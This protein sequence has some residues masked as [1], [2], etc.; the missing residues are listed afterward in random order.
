MCAG[1]SARSHVPMGGLLTNVCWHVPMGGLLTY[2]C[3]HASTSGL[4]TYVL[5]KEECGLCDENGGVRP[6]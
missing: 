3:S 4:L 5:Q 1:I 2:V 6:L